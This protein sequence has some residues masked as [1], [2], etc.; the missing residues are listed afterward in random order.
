MV[1]V[2][3][4]ETDKLVGIDSVDHTDLSADAA[5]I[6]TLA[7]VEGKSV[8]LFVATLLITLVLVEGEL[9]KSSA[10]LFSVS[11]TDTFITT[12]A[13]EYDTAVESIEDGGLYWSDNS[14]YS[15]V[16]VQ[17][18]EDVTLTGSE[19]SASPPTALEKFVW[20]PVPIPEIIIIAVT[21]ES[22]VV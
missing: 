4:S 2:A 16:E 5:E 19:V 8:T 10:G 1:D 6:A 11:E 13:D 22:E 18:N 7:P 20:R 17:V 3:S 12:E 21:E 9:V 14:E 15:S